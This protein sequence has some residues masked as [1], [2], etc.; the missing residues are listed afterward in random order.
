M[1]VQLTVNPKAR[2]TSEQKHKNRNAYQAKS[3]IIM[4]LLRIDSQDD[5][6]TK[7]YPPLFS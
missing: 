1:H 6:A 7:I 4:L 2:A 3:G 5:I